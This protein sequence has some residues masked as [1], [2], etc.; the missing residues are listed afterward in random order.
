MAGKVDVVRGTL[1][2]LVL[3]TLSAGTP[4][5]GFGILRWISDATGEA[6]LIE[7]GALY[8][9]LH[10]L[11]QRAWIHGDWQVSEKGRRA[12]YYVL[13]QLGRRQLVREEAQWLRY[14]TAWQAIAEAAEAA[15]A[16][17]RP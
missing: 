3:K 8:P 16:G 6:L 1:E 13:T 7:E 14:L 15:A 11:E 5:H 4:L 17:A 9:A 2:L 10:R 12:K